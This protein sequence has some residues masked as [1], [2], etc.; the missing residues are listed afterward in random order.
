MKVDRVYIVADTY[1]SFRR[2]QLKHPKIARKLCYVRRRDSII[3][4]TKL[5]VYF[6]T[7]YYENQFWPEIKQELEMSFAL[8]RLQE[9]KDLEYVE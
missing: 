2:I 9:I 4:C 7:L 1:V 3:G 6:G 5:S 8:G